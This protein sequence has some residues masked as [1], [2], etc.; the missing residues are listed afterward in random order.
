MRVW[1]GWRVERRV[2]VARPM[3][4]EPPV[5]RIVFGVEERVVRD[6]AVR[7]RSDIL[8]RS[9]CGVDVGCCDETVFTGACVLKSE[10]V[11]KGS[12]GYTSRLRCKPGVAKSKLGMRGRLLRI[13]SMG[14]Q[15]NSTTLSCVP[16]RET[17][18][19]GV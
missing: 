14:E 19:I 9:S 4:E 6:E 5:M 7:S 3:P 13:V 12:R 8:E 17:R 2:A 15:C 18:S 10:K 16:E 11:G 1:K